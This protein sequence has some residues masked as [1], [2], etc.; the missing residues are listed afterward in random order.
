MAP[1]IGGKQIKS[2]AF[3]TSFSSEKVSDTLRFSSP[4]RVPGTLRLRHSVDDQVR[5]SRGRGTVTCTLPWTHKR[6]SPNFSK[7]GFIFSSVSST[8]LRSRMA[9]FVFLSSM[10]LSNWSIKPLTQRRS[11]TVMPAY[12]LSMVFQLR[13]KHREVIQFDVL[14]V[15]YQLRKA[16][17]IPIQRQCWSRFDNI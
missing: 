10:A 12:L 9:S 14:R 16:A 6:Y 2:K 13:F 15:N 5:S 3:V 17:F 4:E 11:L 1:R 8:S 7:I